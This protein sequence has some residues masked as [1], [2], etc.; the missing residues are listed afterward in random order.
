MSLH[1]GHRVHM[2]DAPVCLDDSLFDRQPIKCRVR[3]RQVFAKFVSLVLRHRAEHAVHVCIIAQS[4]DVGESLFVGSRVARCK[5]VLPDAR[6]DLTLR[7]VALSLEHLAAARHRL[8][9]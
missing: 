2:R 9:G 5:V 7:G 4:Y 6:V 1:G 8:L 3:V